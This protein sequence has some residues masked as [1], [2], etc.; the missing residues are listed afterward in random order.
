MRLVRIHMTVGNAKGA[1]MS[2]ETMKKKQIKSLDGLTDLTVRGAA[3]IA[4]QSMLAVSFHCGA[5]ILIDTGYNALDGPTLD[6]CRFPPDEPSRGLMDA[7]IF[8]EDEFNTWQS[9]LTH[10]YAIAERDRELRE[11]AW[12]QA[13][14]PEAAGK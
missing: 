10:G 3:F 1:I 5:F 12:L 14:Y 8:T 6:I 2:S 4:G 7:G 11:L 9:E 13:K